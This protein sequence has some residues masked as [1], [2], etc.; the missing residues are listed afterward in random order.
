[1]KSVGYNAIHSTA[2]ALYLLLLC[3]SYERYISHGY[4]KTVSTVQTSLTVTVQVCLIDAANDE[5]SDQ[6]SAVI[7]TN[8]QSTCDQYVCILSYY[9]TENE[10]HKI[11]TNH[12]HGK[13]FPHM[14]QHTV[15][16]PFY[17]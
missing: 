5:H 8:Q 13:N 14:P 9:N 10:N 16:L 6:T 3:D 12:V 17:I 1:V 7:S 2:T 15:Q 4:N 11:P